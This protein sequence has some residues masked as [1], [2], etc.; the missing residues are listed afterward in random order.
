MFKLE[1]SLVS[2]VITDLSATNFSR[3][4]ESVSVTLMGVSSVISLS[5]LVP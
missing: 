2:S 5:S 4:S 1:M 3:S